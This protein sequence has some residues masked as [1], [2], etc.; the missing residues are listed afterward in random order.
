MTE[1]AGRPAT[2]G[3]TV[4][5]T[6][7]ATTIR[8]TRS[9]DAPRALVWRL[10]ND[11]DRIPEFW[12]PRGTTTRVESYDFR[13]GGRWRIVCIASDGRQDGFGGVFRRIEAPTLVEWTFGYDG[14]PGQEI[15]ETLELVEDGAVTTMVG[16]SF[17][18][19]TE[20]R[21]GMLDSGMEGGLREM[22][23]RFD[24]LLEREQSG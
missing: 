24:E 15:V 18:E 10:W 23:D 4:V 7:D 11:P 17:F 13:V 3:Q 14:F 22:Q 6:P 2:P 20:A 16:T 5:T 19:S 1:P 12:G 9:F 8:T 21:D